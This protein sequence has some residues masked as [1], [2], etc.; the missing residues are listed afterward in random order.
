MSHARVLGDLVVFTEKGNDRVTAYDSLTGAFRW[1]RHLGER[2]QA[3]YAPC[4]F[5]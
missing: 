3:L 2:L 1:S 4:P 5:R